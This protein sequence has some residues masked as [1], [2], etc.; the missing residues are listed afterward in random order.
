MGTIPRFSLE[1]EFLNPRSTFSVPP[2]LL[3]KSPFCV[4]MLDKTGDLI[5]VRHE[6]VNIPW[7]KRKSQVLNFIHRGTV[8]FETQVYDTNVGDISPLSSYFNPQRWT[9]RDL[10]EKF[11]IQTQTPEISEAAS[12]E[13]E[14]EEAMSD[15][16]QLFD[17]KTGQP[18]RCLLPRLLIYPEKDP[19][20][21]AEIADSCVSN[22]ST[23]FSRTPSPP[24]DIQAFHHDSNSGSTMSGIDTG[25]CST[26]MSQISRAFSVSPLEEPNDSYESICT[27][28]RPSPSNIDYAPDTNGA[29]C[30]S[31]K[32]AGA[33]IDES[34]NDPFNFN[35][36]HTPRLAPTTESKAI[37]NNSTKGNKSM[38]QPC[39]VSA[40]PR[41]RKMTADDAI[42]NN[43]PV[44]GGHSVGY[45]QP[46]RQKGPDHAGRNRF[47]S[48]S[49]AIMDITRIENARNSIGARVPGPAEHQRVVTNS[50]CFGGRLSMTD[51]EHTQVGQAIVRRDT[52]EFLLNSKRNNSVSQVED[53]PTC[54]WLSE[55]DQ[56]G[57]QRPHFNETLV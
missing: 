17:E 11:G 20:Q 4:E 27:S 37:A 52:V 50:L 35:H 16:E 21:G 26:T 19:L 53:I 46:K 33:L 23:G 24:T 30:R 29:R 28:R 10:N 47:N 9:V 43:D 15:E 56:S 2:R 7:T 34:T 51:E 14:S 25:T 45:C 44:A 54:S 39:N 1:Y 57:Q 22:A 42:F 49:S 8:R 32:L 31:N 48:L 3:E 55:S 12:P 36:R 38:L 18:I 13:L 41:R 40:M 6:A 5:P